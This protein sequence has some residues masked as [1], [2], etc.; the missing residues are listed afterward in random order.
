M[1]YNEKWVK[2][3]LA[4]GLIR[5]GMTENRY[6][7]KIVTIPNLLTFFRML[8]IPLYVW[9]Y[10]SQKGSRNEWAAA[11]ILLAGLTD[12]LDGA[13]ARR[14]N[15]ESDLGKIMD[16]AVDKIS[17]SAMCLMM[18]ARYP[19]MLWVLLFFAVKEASLAT[20]GYLYMKRTGIVNSA[21]WYGKASSIVQYVVVIS[22]LWNQQMTDYTAHVLIYLC[23]A[24]HLLS[25]ISYTVFYVRSKRS[26][27][28]TEEFKMRRLDWSILVMYLLLVASIFLLIFTSRESY[29]REVLPKP[30]YLF[31]RFASLVGTIGIPA[32]FVGEKLP[33][34]KMDPEAF[35]FKLYGW[36]KE[37]RF[38]EKLGIQYWKN[39]T[40]DMSKYIK[41]AFAKQ[42]NLL[43]DPQHLRKLVQ[44][45]CAAELL[46][47]ILICLSPLFAILMDEY[48]IL[49]MV[50][51]IIG[52]LISLIIQRY[53]RPRI[54]KLV[55]RIEKRK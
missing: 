27:G 3:A 12:V 49:A 29:L 55:K 18:S 5:T 21:R 22:L 33:R 34:E 1:L 14:W 16:P 17:M 4:W 25:L 48:G 6:K 37:G 19:I 35:P 11:V 7:D 52:N 28:K 45:T 2:S 43:R 44:E 32:F 23:I 26:P 51:Y 8:L 15:M 9:L 13:I 39:K 42:G 38:Y 47:L 31:L 50:L 54:L 36:E 30:V 10:L 41:R 24:T 20:L 53:N 46:H 40:P